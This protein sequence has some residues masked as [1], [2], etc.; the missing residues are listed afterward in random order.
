MLKNSLYID[1]RRCA[2]IRTVRN[3]M[4]H[5][6]TAQCFCPLPT[7]LDPGPVHVHGDPTVVR[8]A[9]NGPDAD[10]GRRRV[11]HVLV[12]HGLDRSDGDRLDVRLELHRAL[13][14]TVR[15]HLPA[16]ESSR[17]VKSTNL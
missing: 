17:R 2:D 14:C 8:E 15:Q 16:C 12:H 3:R 1:I 7:Q 9:L 11:I 4:L 13:A 5:V 10:D 6:G